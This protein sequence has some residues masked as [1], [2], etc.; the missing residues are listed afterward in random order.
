M[1][2]SLPPTVPAGAPAQP[3]VVALA[4]QD[5]GKPYVDALLEAVKA[6]AKTQEKR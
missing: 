5:V 4:N 3:P 1:N 6:N 2:P